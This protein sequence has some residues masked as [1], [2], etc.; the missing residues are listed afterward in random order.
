[1]ES[2]VEPLETWAKKARPSSMPG[3]R[4]AGRALRQLAQV[5]APEEERR[6]TA[7]PGRSEER[8]LTEQPI[9]WSATVIWSSSGSSTKK[10]DPASSSPAKETSSP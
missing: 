10:A 2:W 5:V 4:S 8:D 1:M 9:G 7:G 6:T 3:R